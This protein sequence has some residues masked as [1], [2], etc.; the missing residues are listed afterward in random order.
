MLSKAQQGIVDH[1]Q[2]GKSLFLNPATGLYAIRDQGG[3]IVKVDQRPVQ[4][5]LLSGVLQQDILGQCTLGSQLPAMDKPAFEIGQPV[6]WTK[7]VRGVA[8]A[9]LD[10]TVVSPTPK[11]VRIKTGAGD[12]HVVRPA[13]LTQA[14]GGIVPC[15]MP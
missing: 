7:V 10:A 9:V 5:L 1:I 11:Q 13:S 6:R 15:S 8:R 2:A 4:A 3:I 12:F 14:S